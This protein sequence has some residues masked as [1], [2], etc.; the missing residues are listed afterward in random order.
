MGV[1]TVPLLPGDM[2][3]S[4]INDLKPLCFQPQDRP[5]GHAEKPLP[6]KGPKVSRRAESCLHSSPRFNALRYAPPTPPTPVH[7]W[8]AF[9]LRS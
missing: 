5:K 9:R 4:W 3:G 2:Q 8:G 7:P 1:C 6:L